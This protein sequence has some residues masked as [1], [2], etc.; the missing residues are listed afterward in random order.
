[1]PRLKPPRRSI[2]DG[3]PIR[4][5]LIRERKEMLLRPLSTRFPSRAATASRF[6]I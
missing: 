5:I 3:V 1:M 6:R 2:M 4:L